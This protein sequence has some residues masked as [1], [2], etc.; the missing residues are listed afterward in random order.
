MDVCIGMRLH[1][2]IY[3][4]VASVPLIGLV[5]DPKISSFMNYTRQ[6]LYVGVA[7]MTEDKLIETLDKCMKDYDS[8]AGELR[9]NYGHLKEK[10]LLNAKL[11]VELYEKGSVD[12]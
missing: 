1:S 11:A 3:A 5:Y 2:L 9:N 6:R 7:D 4:A 12:I 10:A 8:I